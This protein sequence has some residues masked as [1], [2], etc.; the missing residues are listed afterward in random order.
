MRTALLGMGVGNER[1]TARG[2][3]ELFPAAGNDTAAGRQMNRCVEIIVSD[4]GGSI[5][6]R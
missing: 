1:M 6:P 3:G 2:Y 5:A 4:D